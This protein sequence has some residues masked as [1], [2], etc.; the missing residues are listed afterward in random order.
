MLKVKS[1]DIGQNSKKSIFGVTAVDEPVLARYISVAKI[2][3]WGGG[4]K[5]QITCNV[6]HKSRPRNFRKE[7]FF[8]GQRYRRIED[9]KPWPGLALKQDFAKEKSLTQKLK[10][11]NV[12]IGR[13]VVE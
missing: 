12:W 4:A 5:S 9:K 13:R 2:F 6:G 7:K 10:S 8:V 1:D 11:E 3:D